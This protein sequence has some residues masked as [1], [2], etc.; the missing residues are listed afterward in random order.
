M[1]LDIVKQ[2]RS[3]RRFKQDAVD[4]ATLEQ[5][6]D[7]ARLSP[8]G[9]NKQPL[10][11]FI[12]CDNKTNAEIFP[13]LAWAASIEDWAGP[14]ECERPAAYIVILGDTE[15]STSFGCDHG[16]ASQSILLGAVEKGLRGCILGSVNRKELRKTLD[17]PERF[18]ILLVLALGMPAETVTLETVGDD[19][20]TKYWRDKEGI[21]HV[22]KRSL[23]DII[24]DPAG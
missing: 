20:N 7:L 22:P 10:K 1:M 11:F 17:L 8:S 6:V 15:I 18:N 16:I 13:H 9:G 12:S 4:R 24:V 5:L 23:A 3:H 14:E 2:N 21:H 19:G